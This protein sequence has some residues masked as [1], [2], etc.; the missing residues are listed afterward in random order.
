MCQEEQVLGKEW[1]TSYIDTGL[2]RAIWGCL[3]GSI[4]VSLDRLWL[5]RVPVL[6]CLG[7][8]VLLFGVL[9]P[10]GFRST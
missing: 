4:G 1:G 9:G 5:R 10:E 6:R 2:C 8:L 3:Q 7:L